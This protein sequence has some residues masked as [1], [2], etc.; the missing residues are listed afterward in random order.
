[1]KAEHHKKQQLQQ[2]QPHEERSEK[3]RGQRGV[4][5]RAQRPLDGRP[6][7]RSRDER[8]HATIAD[9]VRTGVEYN[10]G[11]RGSKGHAASSG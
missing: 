6:H 11:G 8:G 2:W 9:R 5:E 4:D 1:M 7:V 3:G 10:V